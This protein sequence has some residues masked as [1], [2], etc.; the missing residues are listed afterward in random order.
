M[1]QRVFIPKS[2]LFILGITLCLSA[3]DG[4]EKPP[5]DLLSEDKMAAILTDIHLAEA[6]VTHLQLRSL[7]SS[8]LAFEQLQNQI[9]KKHRVDTTLYHKSYTF[10]TSNPAYLTGI[11]DKVEKNLEARE[12]KKSLKP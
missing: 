9:W 1:S 5:S 3:C 7:D 10:Y 4:E 11:Y 12:K 6:R 2:L 8:V